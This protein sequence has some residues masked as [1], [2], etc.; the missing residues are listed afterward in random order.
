MHWDGRRWTVLIAPAELGITV[1]KAVTDGR[2]A[3][4]T[5]DARWNRRTW[6][7]YAG[8]WLPNWANPNAYIGMSRIPGTTVALVAVV[9]QGGTLIGASRRLP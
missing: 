2:G 7:E 6:Y 5:P 1:A 9:S 8:V 4:F 3:W